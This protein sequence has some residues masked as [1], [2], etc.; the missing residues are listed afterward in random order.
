MW[1]PWYAIGPS[2][3]GYDWPN[4]PPPFECERCGCHVADGDEV[5]DEEWG[6]L[7]RDC[8]DEVADERERERCCEEDD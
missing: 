1:E 5:E 6:T 3:P 2:G 7:C 4:D 8:A